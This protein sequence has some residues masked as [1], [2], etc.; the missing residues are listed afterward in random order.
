MSRPYTKKQL[1]F[2]R[3]GFKKLSAPEL[4]S[5]FNKKFE[6]TKTVGA[7]KAVTG[8]HRFKSGRTGHFKKSHTPWNAGTK[9][10]VRPNSGNFDKGHVPA[11]RKP[12]GHE[13]ICSKDG[14]ILIKVAEP[15]PY[16]GAPTRY[17]HKHHVVWEAENG[18]IPDN[19]VVS[20]RDGDKINCSI[21]NL[22]LLSRNELRYLNYYSYSELPIEMRKSMRALARLETKRFELEKTTKQNHNSEV[23]HG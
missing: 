6:E 10:L 23:Q 9:G 14:Y 8:N 1:D 11:N 22:T 17:R 21:D 2:I 4:T 20:F 19:H 18:P 13:R 15:N 16:T 12:L 3:D 5:A 7:I